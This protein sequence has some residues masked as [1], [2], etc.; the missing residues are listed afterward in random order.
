MLYATT[1]PAAAI[2]HEMLSHESLLFCSMPR[3]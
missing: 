3:E 1:H 2:A